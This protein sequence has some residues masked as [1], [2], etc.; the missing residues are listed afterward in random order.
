[1]LL[2]YFAPEVTLPLAS[3]VAAAFGFLV[4]LGRAPFQFAA[5]VIRSLRR[6]SQQA[7]E[8]LDR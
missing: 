2:A 5:R 6:G 8:N 3:V 7:A 4:M 1:M